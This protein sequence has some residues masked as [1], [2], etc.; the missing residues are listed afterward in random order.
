MADKQSRTAKLEHSRIKSEIRAQLIGQQLQYLQ[1]RVGQGHSPFLKAVTLCGESWEY[2]RQ[3]YHVAKL[4]IPKAILHFDCA[5]R[6]ELGDARTVWRQALRNQPYADPSYEQGV[7]DLTNCDINDLFYK[8][9]SRHNGR[10]TLTDEPVDKW[11]NH[12]WADYCGVPKP[13]LIEK[14]MQ[15]VKDTMTAGGTFYMTFCGRALFKKEASLVKPLRPYSK[16]KDL[17]EA[18]I[19]TVEHF[20]VK[21]RI[22]SRIHK[23]YDVTYG[24]GL[25]E[26]TKMITLGFAYKLPVGTIS[27]IEANRIDTEKAR[28]A[29]RTATLAW[30]DRLRQRE[31]TK[32]RV[33]AR[34]FKLKPKKV[35]KQAKKKL[36]TKQEQART[37]VINEF[38]KRQSNYVTWAKR[39]P[40]KGRRRFCKSVIQSDEFYSDVAPKIAEKFGISRQRVS[41]FL[42]W[43][44]HGSG[45]KLDKQATRRN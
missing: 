22:R 26:G 25:R 5:E 20:A 28:K 4:V 13:E 36:P 43:H 37:E 14:L 3:L 33:L 35:K 44:R 15:A 32:Q 41:G 34:G 17:R 18:I 11:F 23:I 8:S 9:V 38:K 2:E 45:G 39:S 27:L 16:S 6:S 21:N 24:G 7:F 31:A 10:G 19:D 40:D 30:D 29:N 1:Y 12:I 42:S